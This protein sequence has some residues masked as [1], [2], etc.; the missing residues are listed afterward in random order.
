[1]IVALTGTPGTGKTTVARILEKKYRVIYLKDFKDTRVYYDEARDT[2]VVDIDMLREKIEHMELEGD[3]IIEGHYSHEMP[4]DMAIVLRCHPDEL[5]RRLARRGYRDIKIMEN[6][7]AE[8]MGIIA[9][10]CLA[11]F[12]EE[13]VFEIDTSILTP[14]QVAD[15]V[16]RIISG[17]GEEYR[18]RISYMGEIL[19][20]Y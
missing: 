19:K 16:N 3:V 17:E 20:W 10:E 18:R 5:K 15:A 11:K 14:E 1:M 2:Y 4:V 13:K 9:E 8:A 6:V 7:E 12:P